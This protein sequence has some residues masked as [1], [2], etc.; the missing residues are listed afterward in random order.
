MSQ[1]STSSCAPLAKSQARR[2]LSAAL[3]L[4][5]LVPSY[6]ALPAQRH[7]SHVT[8]FHEA[9]FQRP[10]HTADVTAYTCYNLFNLHVGSFINDGE[11]AVALFNG[12]N[13]QGD[14]LK[15][16]RKVADTGD[17]GYVQ[18]MMVVHVPAKSQGLTPVELLEM[19]ILQ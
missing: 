14:A 19:D 2:L 17:F 15:G 9:N 16:V 5:L 10:I 18:S 13:C 6:H 3:L 12:E 8:L 11:G 1:S 7:R 4:T